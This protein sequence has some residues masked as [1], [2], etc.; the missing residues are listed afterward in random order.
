MVFLNKKSCNEDDHRSFKGNRLS[1]NIAQQPQN[2][3]N[4]KDCSYNAAHSVAAGAS[5][6]WKGADENKNQNNN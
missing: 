2:N 6:C 4:D 1:L 3:Y 5:P